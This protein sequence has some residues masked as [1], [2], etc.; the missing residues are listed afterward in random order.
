MKE[1]L[2]RRA[3]IFREG[4]N[5]KGQKLDI[6]QKLK[7]EREAAIQAPS[8]ADSPHIESEYEDEYFSHLSSIE[9]GEESEQ[10]SEKNRETEKILREIAKGKKTAQNLPKS[11]SV[12]PAGRSFELPAKPSEGEKEVGKENNPNKGEKRK[13]KK[14]IPNAE[15]RNIIQDGK[16]PPPIISEENDCGF[17]EKST[18][19]I[20][21]ND[22][23]DVEIPMQERP[24][25]NAD[26][27]EE[28]DDEEK[29]K[30]NLKITSDH[31]GI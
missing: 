25:I 16:K 5:K 3:Q 24:A 14:N 26:Q 19:S 20:S 22:E 4:A 10:E 31:R 18:F 15:K 6:E 21:I 8:V 12:G 27:E 11:T 2:E 17:E 30:E 1:Y 29:I 23:I 7:K 28:T 9:S 13:Q